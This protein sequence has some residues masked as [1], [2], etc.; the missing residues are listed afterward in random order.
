MSA[1][2]SPV[3]PAVASTMV[4]PGCNLPSRSA[5]SII[6]SAMRSLIEPLGLW[7][8]SLRKSWQS[9]VSIRVIST[10][11]VSPMSE[12]IDGGFCAVC[13]SIMAA[14]S[15]FRFA[16]GEELL[17]NVEAHFSVVHRVAKIAAFVNP[18]CGNPA[19][20]KIEKPLDLGV[21][22]SRTGIGENGDVGLAGQ[23]VFREQ[24]LAV[25]A[26]IPDRNEIKFH[27]RIVFHRL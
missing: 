2:P 25:F 8:S 22:L 3:L 26:A 20:R 27:V 17:E 11:G 10:S 12:R 19:Q 21:T 5:A 23:L 16:V 4:P 15:P 24:R 14:R 1:R 6:E 7:F 18:G 9:P 13:E